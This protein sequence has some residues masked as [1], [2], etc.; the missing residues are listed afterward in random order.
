MKPIVVINFKTYKQGDDVLKLA[1]KIEKFDKKI[2]VGVQSVDIGEVVRRTKLK[3]FCQHVDW[4]MPG[5]ET[6]FILPEAVKANGANGVFLNHSEHKLDFDILKKTIK[7]CREVKLK[8]LVFA[9]DLIQAKKIQ[10]L[11]PDYLVIEPPKLVGGNVSVSKSK[12]ELIKKIS[13]KLNGNFLVGAGI[14]TNEDVRTAMEL[15]A[16]GIA[17]SSVITKSKNPEKKLRELLEK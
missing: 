13:E 15:G 4:Q 2:V 3:V 7:R 11:K 9:K 16:S 1:K 10:K 12:P 14:K 17:I 5:R 8:I 6:G